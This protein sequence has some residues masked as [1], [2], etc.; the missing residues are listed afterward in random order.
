MNT[1]L[2]IIS[3][4]LHGTMAASPRLLATFTGWPGAG[5]LR[6]ILLLLLFPLLFSCSD[7]VQPV[8]LSLAQGEML[9]MADG[10]VQSL[11]LTADAE[12]S[13]SSDCDWCMVNPVTGD[14]SLVCE[15]RVDSSYLYADREAHL[16]FRT[17]RQS[18]MLTV[19]QFG[20]GKVI[21]LTRSE[22]EVPDFTDYDAL[23]EDIEVQ[24]NIDYDILIEYDDPLRTGWLQVAK[25]PSTR[26]SAVPHA[27]TV[28][29]SYALYTDTDKDRLA[30]VI[31]RQRDVREGETAA[32]TRLTFRQT[33]APEIIPS[34]E[35]D[36]LALLAVSRMLHA[37]TS[38]DTSLPMIYWHNV[39]LEDITYYNTRT[40]E[41]VTEPRV[42]GV[43]MA[44]FDSNEGIPFHI[45]YLDQLRHLSIT[46]N[47]N[48]HLRRIN[49]GE[50]V[51]ALPHLKTLS[52]LGYGISQ[53]PESMAN[54]ENLEVLELS[55]N[56]LT[57]IPIDII[58]A[59]DRH[60][61]WYVNMANN[62]KRDVYGRL[63][64]YASVRDTLGI[65]GELP[66][67]LFQ[68]RNVCYIGL[69]YNYL[70]G[71]IPDMGYDASAYATLEEKIA[72]NP[73]MPQLEQLSVNLNFL[74]GKLPD[75]VLYHK[76]LRCWDPY[77]LLFNQYEGSR[78]SN[79]QKVGFTNEPVSI[80]QVCPL[81][82]DD[83]AEDSP[84]NDSYTKAHPFN[85]ANTFDPGFWYDTY[86]TSYRR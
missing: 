80:E 62:R 55:G 9:F 76:N 15:V 39:T 4:K 72:H 57:E 44:M 38:W 54:M 13:V 59:L 69:S 10:G 18:R 36:S 64:E 1:I 82:Y 43:Q 3:Q 26:S 81:W 34:R 12:W 48:A 60:K 75:W 33:H 6:G 31:F 25:L 58:T 86:H 67:R 65:H 24:S 27:A 2:H 20:Y 29:L 40:H 71:S 22:I 45:R 7:E 42:T 66:Q 47:A 11:Q 16:S 51:T 68:L 17:S 19:R 63:E 73:V 30:T 53:L 37:E 14:G 5:R 84:D 28:R 32:E 49:L 46:A 23:Y 35:G 79:G 77:T 61:L 41:T 8:D 52:L 74:T 56:N 70:E 83:E 21:R 50:H 78:D 85:R